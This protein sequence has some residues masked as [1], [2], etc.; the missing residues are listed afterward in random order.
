MANGT[1]LSRLEATVVTYVRN[2]AD[3]TQE[4]AY[5][6]NFMRKHERELISI[7]IYRGATA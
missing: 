5:V 4:D 1:G 2:E 6:L 7:C 3:E